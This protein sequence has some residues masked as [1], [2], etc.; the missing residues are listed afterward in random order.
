V[1]LI[2]LE[3]RREKNWKIHCVIFAA[4]LIAIFVFKQTHHRLMRSEDCHADEDDIVSLRCPRKDIDKDFAQSE[5]A[6]LLTEGTCFAY[7]PAFDH[8]ISPDRL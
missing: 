6:F 8:A 3:L 4:L 2:V 5:P 1:R 7:Q